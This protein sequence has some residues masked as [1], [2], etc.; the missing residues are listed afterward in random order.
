MQ[1]RLD[2]LTL[3]VDDLDAARRFYLDG[4]G[5]AAALDVPGEVLFLQLNHGL[6]VG[7]FGAADLATDMG[8]D[9][10]SVR[11]GVGFTLAHDVGSPAE[12]RDVLAQALQAGATLVKPAQ[13]AAFGGY[14]AYFADPVGLRWEVAWNPG[15]QVLP[16]GT[17]RIGPAPSPES[18][19][20][21]PPSAPGTGEG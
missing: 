2:L 14:H 3:A 21:A 8:A 16:D 10:A 13:D 20:G 9:P 4:L 12:V 18:S 17:V 1:P 6:L 19:P 5:W 7:L 11:P 15:W